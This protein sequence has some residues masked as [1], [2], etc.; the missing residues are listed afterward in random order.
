[1]FDGVFCRH[2]TSVYF[3]AG[4]QHESARAEI[5]S[6]SAFPCSSMTGARPAHRPVGRSSAGRSSRGGPR[7]RTRANRFARAPDVIGRK[8]LVNNHPMTVIGVAAAGFRGVDP[9]EVPELWIPTMMKRQAT[10]EWD[11][12]LDR[13]AVWMHVFGRLKRGIT[14]DE[15][16]PRSSRGS[17]RCWRPTRSRKALRAPPPSSA[18]FSGIDDR[19][20][21]R[22]P[23]PI[24]RARSS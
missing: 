1:M 18:A 12:L 14:A 19:G 7:V 20:S 15:H 17:S 13:R 2:A 3:A 8:V 5:V 9:I 10:P 23:G 4:T 22:L 24:R 21:A 11:N 6:G 16:R